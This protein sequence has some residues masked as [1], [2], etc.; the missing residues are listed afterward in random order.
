MFDLDVEED[1]FAPVWSSGLQAV[2][3]GE[4]CSL[5]AVLVTLLFHLV[6]S[7]RKSVQPSPR[8]SD[9]CEGHSCQIPSLLGTVMRC[10]SRHE[11]ASF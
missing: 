9:V 1:R 2:V 11:A 7:S 3:V 4:T 5:Y 6:E 8:L 10:W